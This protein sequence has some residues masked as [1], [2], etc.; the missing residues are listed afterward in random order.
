GF[1]DLLGPV[2]GQLS[3]NPR[4]SLLGQLDISE[5][6]N[7]ENHRSAVV[8]DY[9][10]YEHP[11][12]NGDATGYLA[13]HRARLHVWATISG[14]DCRRQAGLGV[15]RNRFLPCRKSLFC[16]FGAR[17]RLGEGGFCCGWRAS[18]SRRT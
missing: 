15:R 3:V 5:L 11:I 1:I 13:F 2:R 4:V 10:K 8:R 6:R 9:W 18:I 16:N 12:G 7:I 17:A 14:G